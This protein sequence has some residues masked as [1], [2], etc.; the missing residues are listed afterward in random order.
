MKQDFRF[1]EYLRKLNAE[2][3]YTQKELAERLAYDRS[4][5][6]KWINGY[7]QPPRNVVVEMGKILDLQPDELNFLLEAAGYAASL[8][9]SEANYIRPTSS[10]ETQPADYINVTRQLQV[11]IQDIKDGLEALSAGI[12]GESKDESLTLA[13]EI[14]NLRGTLSDLQSTSQ[15]ITAPVRIPSQKDMEV[16]LVA[17]TSL[18]RLEEYRS[19]ENIWFSLFG[20]CLGAVMAILI[21][22]VTGGQSTTET[23]IILGIIVAV[24]VTTGG[25]AIVNRIRGN[26]AK[27]YILGSHTAEQSQE[28]Q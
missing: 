2:R 9:A 13:E 17:T 8:S 23:W 16:K 11:Q 7:N 18:E 25:A 27:A 24:A 22:L 21:N 1:G 3:G 15:E 10:I 20:V 28:E 19:D 12:K 4:T 6:S 14:E 5:I 26:R